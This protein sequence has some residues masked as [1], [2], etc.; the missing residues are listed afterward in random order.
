[1]NNFLQSLNRMLITADVKINSN[2]GKIANSTI[3]K[4]V[5]AIVN[6]VCGFLLIL[7]PIIGV[8]AIV[9][10]LIRKGMADQQEQSMWQKRVM[11]AIICTVLAEV[12]V[13]GVN[14]F[15]SYMA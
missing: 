4:G 11:T 7:A 2:G 9:Y 6:D 15:I 3:G 12:A 8:A 1:M 10:F 14:L 5:K 13:A